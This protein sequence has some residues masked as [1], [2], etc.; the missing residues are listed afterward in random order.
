[1]RRCNI[2]IL[3]LTFPASA[4]CT[5]TAVF[6]PSGDWATDGNHTGLA[7]AGHRSTTATGFMGRNLVGPLLEASRGDGCLTTMVVGFSNLGSAG[8]GLRRD[9]A[10]AAAR[11]LNSI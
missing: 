10:A 11:L 9:S 7:L 8:C 3:P 5:P 2:P 4:I 6:I 1:M